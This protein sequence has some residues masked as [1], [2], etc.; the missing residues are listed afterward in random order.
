MNLN[1]PREQQRISL[2]PTSVSAAPAA[3]M[4]TKRVKV[5][6]ES[7]DRVKTSSN[8]KQPNDVPS[9]ILSD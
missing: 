5:K 3:M 2:F 4:T 9:E 8:S 7:E 6:V 1:E